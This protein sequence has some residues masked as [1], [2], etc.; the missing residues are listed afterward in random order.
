MPTGAWCWTHT[1]SVLA[2][3]A[4]LCP[5]FQISFKRSSLGKQVW[6]NTPAIPATQQVEVGGSEFGLA[7]PKQETLFLKQTKSK[8]MG[9]MAQ[10]VERLPAVHRTLG[11]IPRNARKSSLFEITIFCSISSSSSSWIFLV[12]NTKVAIQRKVSSSLGILLLEFH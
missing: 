11:L 9:V 2:S 4:C 12:Q 8:R 1:W 7:K 6:R 5:L 3:P 10:V